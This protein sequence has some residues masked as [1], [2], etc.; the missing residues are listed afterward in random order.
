MHLIAQEKEE[1]EQER[2]PARLP[3]AGAGICSWSVFLDFHFAFEV[4]VGLRN[5]SGVFCPSMFCQSGLNIAFSK[6]STSTFT[7]PALFLCQER[8]FPNSISTLKFFFPSI[9]QLQPS[10]NACLLSS[11]N[12]AT[13][14]LRHNVLQMPV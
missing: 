4:G 6:L 8:H 14:A 9:K 10:C 11:Y 3:E 5:A 7:S 2:I 1:K 13:L 12:K